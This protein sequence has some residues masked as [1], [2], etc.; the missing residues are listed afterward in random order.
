VYA[1]VA[2]DV[3]LKFF[4]PELYIRLRHIAIRA[5]LMPVPKT[6]MDEQGGLPAGEYQIG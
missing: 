1:F 4:P 2:Y 5:A 6:A 3:L